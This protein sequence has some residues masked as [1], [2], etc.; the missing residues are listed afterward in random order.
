VELGLG[1]ARMVMEIV[2]GMG[3]ASFLR[4]RSGFCFEDGMG[5]DLEDFLAFL[6]DGRVTGL[7]ND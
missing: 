2:D 3:L 7:G 5:G 4:V 1:Q 6:V